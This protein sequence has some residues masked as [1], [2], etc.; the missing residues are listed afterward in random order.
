MKINVDYY[1]TQKFLPTK[2]HKKVREREVKDTFSVNITELE[3]DNFPV[4]F[5]IHDMKSV[6]ENAKSYND[7]D[8]TEGDFRMFSEEIR[9]YRKRLYK[10]IRVTSGAAISTLFENEKYVIEKLEFWGRE[11][12]YKREEE[13]HSENSIIVKDNKEEIKEK[14][15]KEAKDYIYCDGKFW[16]VC[17]E[18]R[19]VIITFGS[20]HNHG[21][22]GFF[23]EDCYNSNI[24]SKNSFNALQRDEAIAYGKS[25]ALRRGDTESIDKIGRY[26]N[27]EVVMPE[28]VKVNPN[29]QHGDGDSFI[30][31]MENIIEN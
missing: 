18:P 17:N 1:Y 7:F 25:I 24:P 9:T 6:Y 28:M 8:N 4:A 2:R 14:I 5:I 11:S 27:I 20:G 13:E 23:I 31:T 22:T 16:Y 15:L 30:N 21:G 26:D 10:P 19:Y 12:F 3:I 29:K